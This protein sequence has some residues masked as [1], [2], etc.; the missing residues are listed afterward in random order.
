M[1]HD[2]FNVTWIEEGKILAGSIPTTPADVDLLRSKDI[3]AVI[4]LTR[5]DVCDYPGMTKALDD[6]YYVHVPIPD[7]GIPEDKTLKRALQEMEFAA[8]R[9]SPFYIHCRG[10]IGRTGLILIAWYVIRNGWSLER[11]RQQVRVRRNYQGNASADDQG[12][13]QREYID[14][15]EDKRA[16]FPDYPVDA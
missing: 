11:A 5:R 1:G 6:I 13:P 7:N 12:S 15:L 9:N 16:D 8:N 3:R 14:A 10:G 2:P 4:S